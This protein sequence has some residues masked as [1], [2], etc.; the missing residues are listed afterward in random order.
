MAVWV[1]FA[2]SFYSLSVFSVYQLEQ[3][4]K[5]GLGQAS[6]ISRPWGAPGARLCRGSPR[7]PSR[8]RETVEQ[9]RWSSNSSRRWRK[10]LTLNKF[11]VFICVCLCIPGKSVHMYE[12]VEAFTGFRR[13]QLRCRTNLAVQ[14]SSSMGDLFLKW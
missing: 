11:H 2:S 8:L 13:F 5:G 10:K 1:L 14:L 7:S 12:T 3:E 6:S 9:R 4:Q